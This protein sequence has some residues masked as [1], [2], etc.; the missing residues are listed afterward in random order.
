MRETR[1]VWIL[2]AI[3]VVAGGAV[4]LF[5]VD[6]GS[7]SP[8]PV[9]FDDTISMGISLQSQY[10]L[11]DDVEL[12]RVQVFY[13]QYRY[14]V[15]YY[16]VETFVDAQQQPNHEQRFGYPLAVYVSDYSGT[17]LELTDEGYPR[18]DRFGGW[19]NAEEA[20]FVVD[21]EARTPAGETVIPFSDRAD[22]DAF[23]DEYD[24]T[25]L[26]WEAVLERT[27]DVDT[28]DTVRQ[29]VDEQR[30][31]ADERVAAAAELRDRPE[32]I[33]V[34]ED[35]STIQEAVDEAP[36]NTTVVV[37]EGTYD[38]NVVVNESITL[39]GE[40]APTIHGN[41]N[42]T[43]VRLNADRAAVVG[44]DVT[45]VGNT[46]RDPDVEIET[47]TWDH[48]V[49][50]GYGHGDAGV[51]AVDTS[52]VLIEDVTIETPANGVLLRDSPD[53]VVR[54]VTVNGSEEWAE[55][56]MGVMTM[57]SPGVIENSTFRHGRDGVYMHRSNGLVVR[58]NVMEDGRFGV[59]VM[60][61]SETLIADNRVRDQELSGI[62][63]MTGPE[64]NAIVGNDVRNTPGGIR[65]AGSN[66]YIAGNVVVGNELGMTTA[67]GNS[68]YEHNL[69]ADNDVGLQASSIVP[70]NRVVG[71]DFVDN[72]RHATASSGPLRIY[73]HDGRG[74]YWE[75][76]IGTAEG[77][78]LDRSYSPTDPVDQR[79]HRV[80]GT[81][82]LA[83]SPAL[84]AVEGL[85][86]TVPGM[87]A[88]S[89]VDTAPLCEPA[90]PELFA[91][92][93]WD[94]DDYACETSVNE[95]TS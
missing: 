30:R 2:V 85:Q 73:T 87:R 56:F 54:N 12:P 35:A 23:A 38:E 53:M 77:G 50:L 45:G 46:T 8:E 6:A 18:T 63:V 59:H 19:T 27:F 51:A 1:S 65:T 84:D 10:A 3:L 81:P 70:S 20:H 33:V 25:V 91:D 39:A 93:D 37:P 61:T 60:H 72:D 68:I 31:D 34:G 82:T 17:D 62:I 41:G 14:V 64:L 92:T 48:N 26:S 4:G 7:T 13:S 90:N 24:G 44:F 42:G 74:N 22:A 36:A 21:S 71:N 47:D 80:D 15:G 79:L 29:R 86:G 11:E 66:S 57:R 69:I 32:S 94:P 16:G 67:A 78:V 5:T 49:E 58:N 52:G 88:G 95:E 28:A 75:G 83:R 76:A 9:N 89:V 55:G 40:G 43:V